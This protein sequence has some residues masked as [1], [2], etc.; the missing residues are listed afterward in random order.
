MSTINHKIKVLNQTKDGYDTYH[1]ETNS[2]Q[3]YD[4]SRAKWL[5]EIIAEIDNRLSQIAGDTGELATL[6]QELMDYVSSEINKLN[7][8]IQSDDEKFTSA[9]GQSEFVLANENNVSTDY[10]KVTVGGVE[11]LAPS[12]FTK[13][14]NSEGKDVVKFSQGLEEGLEVIIEYYGGIDARD[15][16]LRSEIDSLKLRIEQLE[17]MV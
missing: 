3:V 9:E 12:N 14:K 7:I 8:F 2:T 11:Q 1:V 10:L 16:T 17:G 5:D 4:F 15:T 6:R 13:I